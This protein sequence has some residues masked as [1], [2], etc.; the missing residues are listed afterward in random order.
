MAGA[1]A[2]SFPEKGG[3]TKNLLLIGD[4]RRKADGTYRFDSERNILYVPADDGYESLAEKMARAYTFLGASNISACVLK[5]DDDVF[6]TNPDRLV[7]EALPIVRVHHY[8]GRVWGIMTSRCWH[9]GK[10][11]DERLNQ[12]PYG[13]ITDAAYANG[14]AYLLSARAVRVLG[15]AAV[16]LH[17]VFMVELYE[18]LAVGKILKHYGIRPFS[19]DLEEQG[20]VAVTKH[21]LSSASPEAGASDSYL[22]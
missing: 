16:Y 1:S 9:F 21:P 18:D 10:C 19:Y 2:K 5:V 15:K 14:P 20:I 6:C 7:S 13:L 11:A 4:S 8:V 12:L 3:E 17:D 22:A